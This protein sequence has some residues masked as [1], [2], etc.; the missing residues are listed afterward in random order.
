MNLQEAAETGNLEQVKKLVE[1]GANIHANNDE[2]LR[3]ASSKGRIEV[4]KYLKRK[5]LKEKLLNL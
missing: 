3:W 5:I 4:V 2:A 1:D